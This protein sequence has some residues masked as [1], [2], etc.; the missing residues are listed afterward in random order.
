MGVLKEK[1]VLFVTH[2]VEF[3]PA[4]DLVIVRTITFITLRN[5][6]LTGKLTC[7]NIELTFPLHFF[8]WLELK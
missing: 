3:L 4:A 8:S 5:A 1:T 2:Q 7:Q 6:V